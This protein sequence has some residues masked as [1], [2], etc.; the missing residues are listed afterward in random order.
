MSNTI[1]DVKYKGVETIEKA[2]NY[3]SVITNHDP[4]GM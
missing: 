2:V 4:G 1:G 3:F